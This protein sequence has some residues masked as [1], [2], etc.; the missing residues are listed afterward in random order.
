MP[1][2][3][4]EMDPDFPFVES[5]LPPLGC[6]DVETPFGAIHFHEAAQIMVTVVDRPFP[7]ANSVGALLYGDRDGRGAPGGLAHQ[8]TPEAAR[9]VAQALMVAADRAEGIGEPPLP[10][11]VTKLEDGPAVTAEV[12]PNPE[13]GEFLVQP[14]FDGVQIQ[15]QHPMRVNPMPCKELGVLGVAF[16]QGRNPQGEMREQ[17]A[18]NLVHSDGTSL[19]GFLTLPDATAFAESFNPAFGKLVE[20]QAERHRLAQAAAEAQ[21]ATKQ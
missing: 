11:R 19:S 15:V 17:I 7:V 12:E 13:T 18:L 4:P 14:Q 2:I 5:T 3:I 8:M 6:M 1:P 21:G 16:I 9:H 20:A 10:E